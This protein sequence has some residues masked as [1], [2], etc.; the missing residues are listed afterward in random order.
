VAE[1]RGF[2]PERLQAYADEAADELRRADG[3]F[4]KMALD[5]GLVTSL[6]GRFEVEDRL[7]Q[8]TGEDEDTHSYVGVDFDS[9][10][11]NV[12]SQ[13]AL[14]TRPPHKVAVIVAS[15]E[16]VPGTQPPGMV[17]SDTLAAQLR[18]ARFDEAVKAV[19]L[20]IDS[21]GG[22]AFA[23][24]VIR[25]EVVALREAG[26]PVVA[27][28]SSLAAS[29]GY[30]IAMSA[31]RIVASP[32]TLTGSIGIFAVFPTFQRTL[33][34]LGVHT[35]GVGTTALSGEFRI[36]RPMGEVPKDLLQQNLE[37]SYRDFVGLAAKGRKMKVEAMEAVAQGRV[38]AGAD[39][40][41]IGLVDELGGY[42]AAIEAAAR[43]AKL[44]DD[45]DV[46]YFDA[47][48]SLGEVFGLR[49]RVALAR[50]IAPLLPQ[51]ALPVLPPELSPLIAEARRLANLKDPGGAY[52]YCLMC[53]ID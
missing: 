12:D 50:I 25:R 33:E 53:S 29:G 24:E 16:I 22:S 1:A 45:F 52:A 21:P 20:R 44:G 17:G 35:D 32:A 46:E 19:V 11:A 26:K 48:T 18:E 31:D 47:N 43:L 37:R 42:P 51:S 28:M 8:I 5:A 38:W 36:D 6:K 2:A 15:G 10:L 23:S 30:W 7:A 13:R 40:K 4:A 49:I 9:Y 3:N 41:R 27:S 14:A 34:R 39:A